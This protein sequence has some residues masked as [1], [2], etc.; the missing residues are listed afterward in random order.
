MVVCRVSTMRWTSW[1]VISMMARVLFGL[2]RTAAQV[3]RWSEYPA[4]NGDDRSCEFIEG[5]GTFLTATDRSQSGASFRG[6][7]SLRGC[8]LRRNRTAVTERHQYVPQDCR[9][10]Q[11][12]WKRRCQR[13]GADVFAASTRD[14]EA[15]C[16]KQDT[17]V[18]HGNDDPSSST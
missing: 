7:G 5:F 9:R 6:P 13:S 1:V 3:E 4:E 14:S 11:R 16:R 8:H 15:R 10:M 17:G 12:P 18:H 2:H